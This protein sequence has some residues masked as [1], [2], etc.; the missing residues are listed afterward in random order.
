MAKTKIACT[1]C[2]L[3]SR[4]GPACEIC[5]SPLP[6]AVR[7]AGGEEEPKTK[8]VA[9]RGLR[10][11]RQRPKPSGK[12]RSARSPVHETPRRVRTR[13][14]EAQPPPVQA[15]RPPVEPA[16]PPAPVPVLIEPPPASI[17]PYLPPGVPPWTPPRM[18]TSLPEGAPMAP[19]VMNPPHLAFVPLSEALDALAEMLPSS[20][21][22]SV[23]APTLALPERQPSSRFRCSRCGQDSEQP[24]CEA[25]QEAFSLL[26]AL[27]GWEA[28]GAG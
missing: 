10:R 20:F 6:R 22:P 28:A 9:P 26:R 25:C 19:L 2:G 21:L 13:R 11:S 18:P 24:Q 16:P 27:S 17:E 7:I 3:F 12:P 4:L 14:S 8:R 5:G 15:T 1:W 23:V